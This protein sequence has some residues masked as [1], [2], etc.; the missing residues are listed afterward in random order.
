MIPV[1]SL[2]L[3]LTHSLC[4]FCWLCSPDIVSN[5]LYIVKGIEL[6]QPRLLHRA[7]KQNV[8]IRQYVQST[9]LQELL[10]K[11]F[12]ADH[13][14]LSVLSDCVALLPAGSS[15]IPAAPAA[16]AGALNENEM[17]I[18][19]SPASPSNRT[20][21]AV[22]TA[23]VTGTGPTAAVVLTILPEVEVYLSTLVLTTLLRVNGDGRLQQPAADL[24]ALL[25]ERVH[26]A[27]NRRSLDVF[28]SKLFFYFS[29][30]HE[31]TQQLSQIRAMLLALYRTACVRHDEFSQAVLLN[32]LLRNYLHYN[33]VDQAYTLS[34][35]SVFPETASNNQVGVSLSLSVC[36]SVSLS[37]N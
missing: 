13:A 20:A 25:V 19:P 9:Q 18:D 23:S 21:L 34:M 6:N 2:S 12:P 10:A 30:A 33:L 15:E 35:R 14:L 7:I 5:V 24:S 36:L 1:D 17:E 8:T 4:V 31:K 3:S 16:P 37:T 28:A 11:Y 26:S 27:F 29:L 32:L 22:D